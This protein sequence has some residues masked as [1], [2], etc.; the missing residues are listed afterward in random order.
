M[1]AAQLFAETVMRPPMRF[2]EKWTPVFRPETRIIKERASF[3]DSTNHGKTLALAIVLFVLPVLSTG[4]RAAE[5]P[6]A[7]AHEGKLQCYVQ[8]AARR[9]CRAI[10]RYDFGADGKIQNPALVLIQA[11]PVTI[12]AVTSEVQEK[13]QAVCGVARSG[14]LD[15]ARIAA[16]GRQLTP[17]ETEAIK[18]QL[19][20]AMAARLDKEVCT[21]YIPQGDELVA[22]VT[23]D[24]APAPELSAAVIWVRPEDGYTVAP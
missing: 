5:D 10:S 13:G 11:E 7:E 23:V 6:L 20:S 4:A 22:Q 2:Q 14:D 12:M 9:T 17:Q 3:L 24:G 16:A 19:K 1:V 21:T 15:Q 18:T 8:D